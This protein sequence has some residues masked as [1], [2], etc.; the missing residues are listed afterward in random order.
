MLRALAYDASENIYFKTNIT[1]QYEL[2]P[3]RSK[4]G[5]E[6]IIPGPLYKEKIAISKKKWDHLQD[7]KKL[8]PA[9]C[10]H[11]YDNLP[12]KT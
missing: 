6:D 2:L 5:I 12:Y 4:F 10:F 11:F 3:Q 8:L 9:D 1:D 7:L